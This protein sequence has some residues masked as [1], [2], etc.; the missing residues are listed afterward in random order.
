MATV[1]EMAPEPH[2]TEG[3]NML[4]LVWG[5]PLCGQLMWM[6]RELYSESSLKIPTYISFQQ[7]MT[8]RFEPR[9]FLASVDAMIERVDHQEQA[10]QIYFEMPWEMTKHL[11]LLEEWVVGHKDFIDEDGRWLMGVIGILPYDISS[12]PQCYRE[13]F[14]SFA[15]E[16]LSKIMVLKSEDDDED[17]NVIGRYLTDLSDNTEL[18]WEDVWDEAEFIES[19]RYLSTG[20][21][22]EFSCISKILSQDEEFLYELFVKIIQGKLGQ[23]WGAEAVWKDEQGVLN[24]KT[25]CNGRM[26]EWSVVEPFLWQQLPSNGCFFN[27][28]GKQLNCSE[29]EKDSNYSNLF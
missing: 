21:E 7:I 3:K 16:T 10:G 25:F 5:P 6:C 11:S 12:L 29:I 1:F 18:I 4:H 17:P 20:S 8:S 24:A 15:K 2:S 19:Y 14:E 9:E 23:V 27:L 13:H 26:L 22:G 28:V